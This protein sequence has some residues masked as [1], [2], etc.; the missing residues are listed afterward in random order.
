[1]KNKKVNIAMIIA[2]FGLVG[3]TMY[4]C[5]KNQKTVTSMVSKESGMI[6]VGIA[7]AAIGC[8]LLGKN[9]K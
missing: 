8:F 5:A 2:G 3:Y 7:V 9:S 6:A 4:T 1:M